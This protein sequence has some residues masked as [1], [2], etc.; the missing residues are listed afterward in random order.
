MK[1]NDLYVAIMALKQHF[2]RE[3]DTFIKDGNL[4]IISQRLPSDDEIEIMRRNGWAYDGGYTFI[5]DKERKK[6]FV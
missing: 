3:L 6:F 1:L 5:L 2:G 4:S